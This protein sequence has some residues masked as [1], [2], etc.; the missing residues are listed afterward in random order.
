[1]VTA[2]KSD[3]YCS[4]VIEQ[5]FSIYYVLGSGKSETKTPDLKKF[6]V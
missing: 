3:G 6:I 2:Q 5:F 1:M 4:S